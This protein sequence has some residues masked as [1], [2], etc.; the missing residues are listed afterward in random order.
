MGFTGFTFTIH[1]TSVTP[2]RC[3]TG[4]LIHTTSSDDTNWPAI[5]VEEV[6][7]V[8]L[9]KVETNFGY[10][11]CRVLYRFTVSS[12]SAGDVEGPHSEILTPMLDFSFLS[13]LQLI[14]QLNLMLF[15]AQV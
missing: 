10:D 11:L 7:P 6:D 14:G 5:F 8:Q 9:P 15:R 3:V 1:S 13:K 2:S 4:F 12:V